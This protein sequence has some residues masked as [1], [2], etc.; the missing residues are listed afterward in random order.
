MRKDPVTPEVA[1]AVLQRDRGMCLA[2]LLDPSQSGT[3][4]GHLT[5][6]HVR[7]HAMMG[8]RA[9]SD[10]AHLATLCWFHHLGSRAGAN[11]ATSHR[12]ALRAYLR[13][14]G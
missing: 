7:D 2:P 12:D 9:P 1:Q 13:Y 14:V 10:T 8:R 4:S 3:C 11:W 6:D 5:F